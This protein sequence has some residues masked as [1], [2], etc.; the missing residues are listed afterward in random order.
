M[1]ISEKKLHTIV[2]NHLF[3]G[4]LFL[5]LWLFIVIQTTRLIS[6]DNIDIKSFINSSIYFKAIF[7]GLIF[8]LLIMIYYLIIY[9]ENLKI[10]I[11][12][13]A[14]LKTLIREAELNALKAQLNPHFLFNSLNSISSMTNSDPLKARQMIIELSEYL[15][16]SLKYNEKEIT[17]LEEEMSNIQRYMNIERIRFGEKLLFQTS[18]PDECKLLKLPHMILQPLFENAVKHGVYESI[19]PVTVRMDCSCKGNELL[20]NITN[21]F[22]SDNLSHTGTGLGLK[23]I[24]NRLKIIYGSDNLIEYS[25]SMNIFKVSMKIPINVPNVV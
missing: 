10:K 23:N 24:K 7:G 14:N 6:Q 3:T 4:L 22:D 13:E 8:I 12:N 16:Y 17:S 2:L 25:K 21:N 1:T 9:S 5:S 19:D 11:R 20:I 18:I 15:R